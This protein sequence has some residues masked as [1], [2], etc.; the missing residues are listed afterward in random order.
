LKG[1]A[2]LKQVPGC[3]DNIAQVPDRT[4]KRLEERDLFVDYSA[5]IEDQNKMMDILQWNTGFNRYK[6]V[7]VF[8]CGRTRGRST[9]TLFLVKAATDGIFEQKSERFL[10]ALK[11]IITNKMPDRI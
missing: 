2:L 5:G 4:D 8:W 11:T 1:L 7:P 3:I 6:G 9:H 10:P